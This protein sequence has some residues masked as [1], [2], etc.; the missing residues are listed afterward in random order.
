M[1]QKVGKFSATVNICAV[2]GFALCMVFNFLFGAYLS[3]MF[4]AFSFVPMIC[5]LCYRT[6]PETQIAG[7]TAMIFAGIYATFIMIVY[8]TQLT[9]VRFGGLTEQASMILDY[10]AFGLFFG[11][12]LLGY[13]MMAL[14]TFF[15]GLTINVKSKTDKGLKFLLM[16]H[17]IFAVSGLIIPMLDI[18]ATMDGSDW[19][20]KFVLMIW[21]VYFAPVGILTLKYLRTI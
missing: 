16:L 15:A 20:G 17:G 11:L 13:S 6:K 7:Y 12:N 14:S 19:V 8:F 10:Q 3:S 5:A 9:T 1:N 4:I 21:C 18:F 2:I